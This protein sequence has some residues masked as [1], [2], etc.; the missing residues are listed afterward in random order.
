MLEA[1]REHNKE[2]GTGKIT[3]LKVW[4]FQGH[5]R[6]ESG[7]GKCMHSRCQNWAPCAKPGESR[8]ALRKL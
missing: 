7:P 1:D 6:P 2:S 4:G 3:G 8:K 5:S